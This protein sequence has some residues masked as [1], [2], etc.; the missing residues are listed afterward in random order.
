[1]KTLIV[2]VVLCLLL[3]SCSSSRTYWMK[4]NYDPDQYQKDVFFCQ[5]QGRFGA[6][7]YDGIL[8]AISMNEIYKQCMY[9]LG[10]FV[11]AEKKKEGGAEVG[12][13]SWK[14]LYPL[15]RGMIFYNTESVVRLPSERVTVLIKIIYNKK[16]VI[17]WV[18]E[19]GEKYEN[20]DYSSILNE[21]DC[22][23]MKIRYLSIH[24]YSKDG[25]IIES[26]NF[27]KPSW[28]FVKP[29]TGD[30]KLFN[31]VCK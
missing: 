14:A 12:G 26:H 8:Y 1:M 16:G 13:T 25:N 27:D 18:K 19:K 4:E 10:Y 23:E 29:E 3:V 30:E 28:N 2:F 17:Y 9:S 24:N 21:I 7:K 11:V 5:Q 6:Y 22:P 20:M 31:A 15:E